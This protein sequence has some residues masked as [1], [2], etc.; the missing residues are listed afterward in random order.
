[1]LYAPLIPFEYEVAQRWWTIPVGS[2]LPLVDG[3][4][5]R[6]IFPGTPGGSSGPDV[7]DAVL[8]M[9]GSEQS[10]LGQRLVGDIEFHVQA[11]DWWQHHHESDPRYN[12]V[13]LHVVL[14][15]ND[16]RPV[17]RQDGQQVPV[18]SLNDLSLLRLWPGDGSAEP[19]WPCQQL[20]PQLSSDDLARLLQHAG[21]LRFEEKTQAFVVQLRNTP[22]ADRYHPYD[23]ALVPALAEGLAYGRDRALFRA[24]GQRL[25]AQPTPLPNPLSLSEQPA[26]L[27]ATRLRVLARLLADWETPGPWLTLRR[28][29][30]P[31]NGPDVAP[32]IVLAALR[33]L[34]CDPGLSLACSDIILCNVVLPFA[35]AVGL[36]EQDEQLYERVH[37][38]YL[39]HPGLSSNR[40]TRLMSA[41]LQITHMPHGSCRQQGLHHIYQQTCR[42]KLCNLC[43]LSKHD[44]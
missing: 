5:W 44:V 19:H 12:H 8:S 20:L 40:V 24:L 28:L 14:N 36:I 34:F 27:D 32:S 6:L 17:L 10:D 31:P 29:L 37:Q 42:A 38:L 13:I 9:N 26:P 7:R 33:T 18:C 25:L 30:V 15:Y 11:S 3:S 16:T 39:A 41:Q 23:Y 43:L 4:C 22:P 1:M 35:A 2:W 21:L